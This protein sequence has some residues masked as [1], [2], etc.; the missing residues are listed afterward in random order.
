VIT[1][2]VAPNGRVIPRR[3]DAALDRLLAASP[4]FRQAHD[5]FS[6]CARYMDAFT[7]MLDRGLTAVEAVAYVDANRI[8]AGVLRK[9]VVLSSAEPAYAAHLEGFLGLCED[10]I[11]GT[12]RRLHALMGGAAN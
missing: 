1:A 2:N 12:E 9:L 4:E 6:T 7:P 8:I 3:D 10:V 11:A 5:E